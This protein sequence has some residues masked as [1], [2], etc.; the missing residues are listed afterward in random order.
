MTTA[1]MD[2]GVSASAEYIRERAGK[3][4]RY[5]HKSAAF[6]IEKV[7]RGE[8][9][10]VWEECSVPD[11]DG[12][13]AYPVTADAFENATRFLLALPLGIP[14]PAVGA[15]PDGHITLEWYQSRRRTLSVSVSPDGELY[16]AA[17]LGPGRASGREPFFGEV[18]KTILELI[19]RVYSC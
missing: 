8:L 18:P 3:F 13:D 11:W 4:N 17:L 1:T 6:G 15:E 2:S 7:I 12:Y 10:E 19:E 9:A 5:L 14:V 16:Y